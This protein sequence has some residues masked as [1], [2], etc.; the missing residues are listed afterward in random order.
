MGKLIPK[1]QEQK[2]NE[3]FSVMTAAASYYRVSL[4]LA[5]MA[6]GKRRIL[7]RLFVGHFKTVSE[8]QDEALRLAEESGGKALCLTSMDED[9]CLG[10]GDTP[11]EA[12]ENE[13][14]YGSGRAG[15]WS[16]KLARKENE[17][18]E[19]EPRSNE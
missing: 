14:K 17:S 2:L 8:Q 1:A 9:F 11:A 19:S 12:A 16:R 3:E 18:R 6:D 13:K 7:H 10:F 5:D 15:C 4:R